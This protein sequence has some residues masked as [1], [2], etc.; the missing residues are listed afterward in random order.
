[1]NIGILIGVGFSLGVIGIAIGYAFWFFTRPKKLTWIAKVYTISESS[2]PL[3][4]SEGNIR[5]IE[6][7]DLKPFCKDVLEKIDLDHSREVY[8]LQKLGKTTP[9]VSNDNIENWG[10]KKE[11]RVLLYNNST[12]LLTCGYDGQ[13]NMIFNPVPYDTQNMIKNEISSRKAKIRKEK[14]I[15][16]AIAPFIAIGFSVMLLL[17]LGYFFVD[18]MIKINK[19]NTLQQQ[20]SNK[21]QIEIAKVL[22]DGLIEYG[23]IQKES[24]EIY[25][26]H[27]NDINTQIAQLERTLTQKINSSTT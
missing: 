23:N 14:D 27:I 9:A 19:E 7:N 21:A 5:E 20:N 2:K 24:A 4:D 11:V 15:L 16:E 12:T 6:L 17:G 25:G 26:T 8:R 1:M 10:D 22:R 3:L 18:G 13:G